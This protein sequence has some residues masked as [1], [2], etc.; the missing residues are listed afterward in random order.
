MLLVAASPVLGPAIKP[1]HRLCCNDKHGNRPSA[2]V[3]NHRTL[4]LLMMLSVC[5]VVDSTHLTNVTELRWL[6]HA[7]LAGPLL[8][9]CAMVSAKCKKPGKHAEGDAGLGVTSVLEII[10]GCSAVF[11]DS[12]ELCRR[13][14]ALCKHMFIHCK[15]QNIPQPAA[16]CRRRN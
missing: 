7:Q 14:C 2:E 1:H 10:Y 8:V 13:R 15:Q 11:S 16:C 6:L 4:L 5:Q 3:C 9:L 12:H